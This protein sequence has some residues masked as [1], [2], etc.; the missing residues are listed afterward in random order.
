MLSPSLLTSKADAVDNEDDLPPLSPEQR[1][2]AAAMVAH[3]EVE[4]RKR[5]LTAARADNWRS[6]LLFNKQGVASPILANAIAAFRYAP[7]WQD[8]LCFDEFSMAAMVRHSPPW[9]GGAIVDRK[10]AP[11]DDS[12]AAEWL[13]RQGIMVSTAIAAEAVEVVARDAPF[14]PLRE[15][16]NRV[17]LEWDGRPRVGTWLSFYLGVKH[18][19]YAAAVGSAWMI[20]AVARVMEPGAKADSMLIIEGSQGIGKS[21]AIRTLAD[22]WFSDELADLGSKDA[23]LQLGGNWIFELSELGAMQKAEVAKLKA[24]LSCTQDR[25]RPPYGRRVIEVPRQCIFVGTT[26]DTEYLKDATGARRFWP[27]K[28]GHILLRDLE[29][30]RDQLWGEA[31]MLYRDRLPWW[32]TS[33]NVIAAAKNEQD[34]RYVADPWDDPIGK[35]LERRTD[36]SIAEILSEVLH[37]ELSK[38]NQPEQNRVAKSLRALGWIKYQHRSGDRR[39]Y[40]YRPQ[41]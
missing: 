2:A 22:P 39:T 24:F 33:H 31:V 29:H 36:T 14:H 6:Q 19:P 10:W 8:V 3:M 11:K 18:S 26:N 35:Y 1:A 30:D 32:L 38:R 5:R 4:D 40:R 16:L 15:Y 37:L 12:L 21:R 27:V 23:S 13:Q 28:A 7:E 34:Q 41:G 25:F 9:E 20:S 17:A